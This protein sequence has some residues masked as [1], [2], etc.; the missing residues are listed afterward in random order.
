MSDHAEEPFRLVEVGHGSHAIYSSEFHEVC[1]PGVGPGEEAESLYVTQLALPGRLEAA[2]G[3]FVVWDV[4]M[5]SAANTSA[6]IASGSELKARL[7]LVSFD[8]SLGQL[9]FALGQVAVFPFLTRLREPL[10]Q[11]MES[12]QA[13]FRVGRLEV[14]WQLELADFPALADAGFSPAIPVP[15]AILWDPHSPPRNPSMWT[16]GLLRRVYN[17]LDPGK[18]CNLATYSRSTRTRVTLLMA[19]FYVGKGSA[20]GLKEESTVAANHSALLAHPLDR[21]WLERVQRSTNAEPLHHASFPQSPI[22]PATQSA[23]HRHAQF[24]S[25]GVSSCY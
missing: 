11:L 13:Q 5:G 14:H 16:L 19:G 20:I 25:L 4:G 21:R 3:E 9:E 23:L 12:G 22:T 6:V 8:R 17:A 24:N 18:P 2:S 7:R 1:H 15:D 10:A